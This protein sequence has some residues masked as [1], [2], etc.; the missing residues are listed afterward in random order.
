M[1]YVVIS[2]LDMVDLPGSLIHFAGRLR[3]RETDASAMIGSLG[4]VQ[5]ALLQGLVEYL[6]RGSIA[7]FTGYPYRNSLRLEHA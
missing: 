5:F 3:R 6:G 2:R 4:A 1:A 7:G